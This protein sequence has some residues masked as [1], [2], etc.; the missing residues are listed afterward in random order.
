MDG[1]K[2]SY[3]AKLDFCFTS[4]CVSQEFSQVQC[5]ITQWDGKLVLLEDYGDKPVQIREGK[6]GTEYPG[7]KQRC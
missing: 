3:S 1:T 4:N 7:P 2:V 5:H 6:K